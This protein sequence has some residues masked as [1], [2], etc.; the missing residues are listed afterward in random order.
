MDRLQLDRTRPVHYL[1]IASDHQRN[2]RII[3]ELTAKVSI[4]ERIN[5]GRH[6]N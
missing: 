2:L 6:A 1:S 3:R 5:T 4:P